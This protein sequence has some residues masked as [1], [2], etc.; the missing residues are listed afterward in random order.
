MSN[1]IT[2]PD[3]VQL[4]FLYNISNIHTA[5]PGAI[6]DYD[7]TTQKANIQPLLN[8]KWADG[9]ETP[10]PVLSNI[11]VIFP[12]AGGASLTFP[13]NKGDYCLV[14][15]IERSTDLWKSQGGLVTPNDSRKFD[16]SD[17]VA[18]MGL[19]P[20]NEISQAID[21]TSVYLTFKDSYIQIKS[22]GDIVIN[23]NN[24]VA[25]G[26]STTE[27]LSVV[28]QI[29]GYLSSST[30]IPAIPSTPSPPLP[31]TFAASAAIL[32]TQLNAIKGSIP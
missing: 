26:N 7:F 13:V 27:L 2:L 12:R 17:G 18:I 11:P 15:F 20:F 23:T 4:A 8:K 5:L 9:T 10:L 6:I 31:L 28:S 1:P 24:K 3:A 22:S 29:L 32:Q 21:N 30:A 25:M 19:Y 16:L 14:L